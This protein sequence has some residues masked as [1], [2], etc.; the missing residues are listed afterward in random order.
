MAKTVE[1]P[2]ETA[3]I[4]AHLARTSGRSE[5]QIIA[6]W[7]EENT[8]PH[9]RREAKIAHMQC[10]V[11]EGL[12]SGRSER[13]IEELRDVARARAGRAPLVPF[14]ETLHLDELDL[15]REGD[16]GRDVEM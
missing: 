5:A 14:L 10:L 8:A 16:P 11:T 15:Q 3:A 2:D 13:T 7:A 9:V 12:E 1:I 4:L 6:Q